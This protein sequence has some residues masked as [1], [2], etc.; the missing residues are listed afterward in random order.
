M[1]HY[2]W[3]SDDYTQFKAGH[4][5]QMGLKYVIIILHISSNYPS[6]I[7]YFVSNLIAAYILSPLPIWQSISISAHQLNYLH[8]TC[9]HRV[10]QSK[11]G[12]NWFHHILWMNCSSATLYSPS[13]ILNKIVKI[14]PNNSSKPFSFLGP[15]PG[16]I[17]TLIRTLGTAQPSFVLK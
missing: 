5:Q 14:T 12:S 10:Y 4:S 7:S 2:F 11:F 13:Y 6:F 17:L 16:Q 1:L 15:F 9:Y 3:D 8:L